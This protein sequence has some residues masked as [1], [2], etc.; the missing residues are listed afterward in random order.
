MKSTLRNFLIAGVGTGVLAIATTTATSQDNEPIKIGFAVALSGWMAAYDEDPY[1][2]AILKIEEINAAGGLLG[3][4]IEYQVADTKTDPTLAVSAA[5]TLVDWGADTMVVSSDYDMGSPSAFVAQNAG[6][7]AISA[8]ASDPLMGTQG[9]GPYTFSAHTAGQTAAFVMAEYAFKE[10]G[11]K[12][13]YQL[14]DV[15]I[16]ATQSFCAGFQEAWEN[17]GGTTVGKDTFQNVDSSFAVQITRIKGLQEEPDA[18]VLC[19]NVPVGVTA[20]RQLRAADIN[21]PIV[22]ETGMSGD[23]WLEGVPGLADFYVPTLMSI[24]EPDP[25]EEVRS[26]LKAY[27]AR[28]DGLPTSEYSVL[29]Y[30]TVEQWAHAVARAE[31]I[32]TDAVVSV[33]NKFDDEPTTCGPTSYTDKIHIQINRP[34]L[35]M[36]VEDGAFRPQ[37]MFRN[38]AVPDFELFR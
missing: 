2:A 13:A 28:W 17:L 32:E 3:R 21:T 31:T 10:L 15:S 8:G 9:V 25:R 12:T 24:N 20:T 33:M 1:K 22:A 5:T 26:F 16:Q 19:G 36:K 34:Q 38:E 30:C 11:M 14:V 37:T 27:E 29:G 18:I 4:Q 7:I 23:F 6:L 35:I